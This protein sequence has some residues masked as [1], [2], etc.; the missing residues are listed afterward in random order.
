MGREHPRTWRGKSPSAPP[1]FFLHDCSLGLIAKALKDHSRP[2]GGAGWWACAGSSVPPQSLRTAITCVSATAWRSHRG[3]TALVGAR[4]AAPQHRSSAIVAN[5]APDG[6]HIPFRIRYATKIF[7]RF[8]PALGG[9]RGLWVGTG[10]IWACSHAG[11]LTSPTGGPAFLRPSCVRLVPVSRRYH[12]PIHHTTLTTARMIR[13]CRPAVFAGC[14]QMAFV[15]ATIA[16][17][18]K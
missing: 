15:R 10:C 16:G 8:V 9:T 1:S 6:R 13:R 7:N 3:I 18:S 14:S 11:E 17:V 4:I 12:S 2:R 5:L